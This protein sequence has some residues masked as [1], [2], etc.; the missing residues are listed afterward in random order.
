MP[1][2]FRDDAEVKINGED[3]DEESLF[4]SG[5]EVTKWRIK[6]LVVM[7]LGTMP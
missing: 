5:R 4:G 6:V 1:R 7:F 3:D 2:L